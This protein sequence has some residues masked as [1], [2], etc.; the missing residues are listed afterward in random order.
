M[1]YV[2]LRAFHHVAEHG[3][4]SRAAEA[5]GLT[6][7]AISDQVRRLENDYGVHLFD[8]RKKQVRL[9]PA[10]ESL[11]AITRR[12]FESEHQALE[13]LSESRALR[14]GQ[15]RIVADSAHHLL[16]VL[17]RFRERFPKVRIFI[18]AGN[19]VTVLEKLQSY[20]ADIG[21][22][23]EAPSGRSFDT[24]ALNSTPVVAFVAAGSELSG[25]SSLGFSD[26]QTVTLVVREEGSKTRVKVLTAAE[27]AGVTLVPGIEAE[28]REAVREI[29]ASGV[30]V[31][32]VSRAEL[33]DD[34]RIVAIPIEPDDGLQMHEAL[35]CLKERRQGRL[36]SAFFDLVAEEGQRAGA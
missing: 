6:Q 17:A 3:G 10:G 23:G 24:V 16:R 29:V 33:G 36:V 20:D 25:R 35:V 12:M 28:G 26:L 34:A 31:G 27:R 5:L 18:S 4:F 1:R 9:T 11:A 14:D 8:R 22:M 32:F 30:G 15:L 7:P 13:L 21:V 2:Q 19:S